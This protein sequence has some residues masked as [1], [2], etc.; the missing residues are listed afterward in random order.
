MREEEEEEG[1]D[2]KFQRRAHSYKK[3]SEHVSAAFAC[4]AAA[5]AAS[6]R[7]AVLLVDGVHGAL[8]GAQQGL[9]L[10]GRFFQQETG[11]ELLHVGPSLI[12]L[13]GKS[14]R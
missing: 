4:A 1:E 8:H 9:Y 11:H 13:G 7:L 2:V 5:A 6:P 14:K 3:N 12:N 10:I